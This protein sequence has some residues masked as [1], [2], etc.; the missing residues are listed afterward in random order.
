MVDSCWVAPVC[1]SSD[2]SYGNLIKCSSVFLQTPLAF[3]GKSNA[4]CDLWDWRL[5]VRLRSVVHSEP[6]VESHLLVTRVPLTSHYLLTLT[7]QGKLFL[8]DRY[9]WTF[10]HKCQGFVNKIN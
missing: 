3:I 9:W 10:L 2:V 6:G 5:N 4:R 7:S 8:W 1:W